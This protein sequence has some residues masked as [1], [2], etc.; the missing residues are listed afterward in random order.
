M[1]FERWRSSACSCS[2]LGHLQGGF[3]GV[4]L[5]FVLSGFL[6]TSLLLRDTDGGGISL[7]TFWTR[8]ARR[9]LPAV[10]MMIAVASVWVAIWG[11]PAEIAGVRRSGPWALLYGSNWFEIS[12]SG[13][14][15]ASFQQ[16][17]MF[18]HLWSLAIEEQFYV[19]WPLVVVIVWRFARRPHVVLS[20]VAVAGAIASVAVM[21]LLYGGGD[22]TRVYMGTDT[23]ASSILLGA[24]LATAP[25]VRLGRRLVDARP[26]RVDALLLLA[27]A[28]LA[29]AWLTIDGASSQVLY[30]GGLVAHS[31]LCAVIM[32]LLAAGSH[33]RAARLLAAP[34]LRWIGRHSYGLY[35][36]HWPVYVVLSPDRMGVD[37]W[38]LTLVRIAVS[39]ACAVLSLRFVENPVRFAAPAPV[40]PRRIPRLVQA[41]A[42]VA[43]VLF[44]IPVPTTEIAAFDPASIGTSTTSPLDQPSTTIAVASIAAP[45]TTI[46]PVHTAAGSASPARLA[47]Q[48]VSATASAMAP[49]DSP[50]TA[51]STSLTTTTTTTTVAALPSTPIVVPQPDA[52]RVLWL[53]DSIAY[54]LAPGLLAA[55]DSAGVDAVSEAFPGVRLVG[56]DDI[57]SVV[58]RLSSAIDRIRPDTVILQ[59][60]IWDADD[61]S[62]EQREALDAFHF[63][64][65]ENGIRVF[66]VSSPPTALDDSG[67]ETL[68]AIAREI[69][70]VDSTM[71]WFVD[72]S[73]LWGTEPTLDA[74]GDGTPERKRDR[75]HV[76]P[77]GA[78]SFAHWLT[79]QLDQ[80]LDGVE[81]ASPIAWASGDWASDERYDMPVGACAP[82]D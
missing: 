6:I 3:L 77:A 20:G 71:T 73:S 53:G 81:P 78:A 27:L 33:G 51:A 59:L 50:T 82:V 25:A 22:P 70:D 64:I 29:V 44:V 5:F 74:D 75:V 37:G 8:R 49:N 19:L 35:L 80:R 55:L 23:R 42:A 61:S 68:A 16:P 66:Y 52:G 62:A 63:L 36:W 57:D 2:T 58:G 48:P 45:A 67:T 15:W 26:E 21:A 47:N 56:G 34:S 40:G 14:Y 43:A 32:A 13:G 11:S 12:E 31:A 72:A 69:A 76:C 41:V 65:R 54:D 46:A 38:T 1:G 4:D 9:L 30:R 17:G 24:A 28:A 10:L 60:S 79:D 7:M 18:D 39:V